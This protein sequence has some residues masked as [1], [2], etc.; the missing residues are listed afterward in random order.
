MSDLFRTAAPAYW[1][2]GLSVLPLEHGS[3]RPA[4]ALTGW[5]GYCNGPAAAGV[6]SSW[7]SIYSDNGIGLLLSTQV[8]DG[9]RIGAVDIDDDRYIR[10]AH[11]ILGRCPSRKRG[12]KGETIFVVVR[13][14]QPV[15]S[16]VLYNHERAQKVDVLVNGKMTVLPPSRHPE[17]DQPYVWLGTPLLD[18]DFASLPVLT[19]TKLDLLRF[20]LRA[21]QTPALI[22]A[23]GT[24][25]AGMTLVWR[26]VERGH[27]DT[28]IAEIVTA[29]LPEQYS[30]NSLDELPGWIES[31]RRKIRVS[32]VHHPLDEEIARSVHA[33]LAPLAFIP[34]E[35]FRRYLDGSWPLLNEFDLNLRIKSAV[36][37]RL[38]PKQQV[39]SY[40][41]GIR[42]CLELNTARKD[43]GSSSQNLIGLRNGVFDALRGSFEP[44]RPE[45]ELRYRLDFEY[46]PEALCPVYERQ[47][48]DTFAGDEK[49]MALFDEFAGL[50]LVPDMRFQKA[51]YL[52][53]E[54]GS[55]KS[56]LLRVL[57]SMHDPE[58][59]SVTPLDRLDNE[60]YLTN[61]VHKLVCIS[62]D[63]QTTGKVFGEA[64][65]R[66][67]GGD[68]I[69]VRKLYQEVEGRV[70][71][72]VRF[73]GSMNLNIP[74]SI[75][76]ADALR[77]RLIFLMCGERIAAPDRN[78]D[79]A[80]QAER[81]GIFMRWMAA[82]D[83]LR[84]RGEFDVPESSAIEVREYTTTQDPVATFFAERLEIDPNAATL[85]PDIVRAYNDWADE[86]QERRRSGPYLS[87]RLCA[88][89]VRKTWWRSERALCVRLRSLRQPSPGGLPGY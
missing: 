30:G 26:L 6:R 80:L 58:A 12:R 53:G 10:L 66:I 40:L 57:E 29:L 21:E 13:D 83:R 33:S 37:P 76:A 71:P 50:T 59:V 86:L 63:V 36:S 69:A 82:L 65:I 24:H 3:K 54:A 20:I 51:M 84:R 5:Q 72:S 79:S 31:A 47:L 85:I 8:D 4:K 42:R 2:R 7:M 60:R 77:R 89:G 1:D 27:D 35:G 46:D 28:L 34:G 52:I 75:G 67:T 87:R 81:P 38:K 74:P 62:F 44:H 70:V 15:K 18:C 16:T 88:L 49:T 55:G 45:N 73:A 64:F 48:R 19:P 68:P 32:Q 43:F 61:L 17:T 56:T 22:T 11:V 78:R 39:S 25:D 9:L 14:D 23:E 41:N